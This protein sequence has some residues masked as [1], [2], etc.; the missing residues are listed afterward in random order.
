MPGREALYDKAPLN[1]SAYEPRH[2][3][4]NG[5]IPAVVERRGPASQLRWFNRFWD[6]INWRSWQHAGEDPAGY[7]VHSA[8]HPGP[9]C[10]GCMS[11]EEYTGQPVHDGVCCYRA[12]R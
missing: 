6:A 8:I 7:Y 4:I 5:R 12:L 10:A 3:P 1:D 9:C 2:V 11:D